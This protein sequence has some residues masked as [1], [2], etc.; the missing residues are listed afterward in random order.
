ML[1]EVFEVS[2]KS[3]KEERNHGSKSLVHNFFIKS[4]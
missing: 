3:L 1:F 4:L 2:A